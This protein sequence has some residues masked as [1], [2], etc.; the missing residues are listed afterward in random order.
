MSGRLPE[1]AC[2]SGERRLPPAAEPGGQALPQQT[3]AQLPTIKLGKGAEGRRGSRAR[4]GGRGANS[5]EV[6]KAKAEAAERA[7]QLQGGGQ[8]HVVDAAQHI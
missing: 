2:S 3:A 1:A 7:G 6:D 8:V 5:Q 4:W